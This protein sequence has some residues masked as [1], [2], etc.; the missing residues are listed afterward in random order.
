MHLDLSLGFTAHS[1]TFSLRSFLTR[2]GSHCPR[3]CL[4]AGPEGTLGHWPEVRS[5]LHPSLSSTSSCWTG[6]WAEGV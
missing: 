5:S 4:Q 2:K 1:L 6:R 3:P